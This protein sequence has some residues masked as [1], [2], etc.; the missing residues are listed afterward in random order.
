MLAITEKE[1]N[2]YEGENRTSA[3]EHGNRPCV[4]VV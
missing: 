3:G 1:G 4:G 2:V